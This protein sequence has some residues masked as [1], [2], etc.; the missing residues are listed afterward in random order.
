MTDATN[1]R[2]LNFLLLFGVFSFC[3]FKSFGD[4]VFSIYKSRF[5]KDSNPR[6]IVKAK[7]S[8]YPSFD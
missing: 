4:P 5:H 2:N 8:I 1:R 6:D 3:G 7:N